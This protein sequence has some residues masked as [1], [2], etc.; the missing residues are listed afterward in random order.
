M[1]VRVTENLRQFKA[2]E[3][4]ADR[5]LHLGKMQFSALLS[6]MLAEFAQH[7]GRRHINAGDGFGRDHHAPYR[8][9][10]CLDGLHQPL[11][12]QFGVGEEQGRVPAEQHQA[13]DQCG[14]RVALQ[15]VVAAQVRYTAQHGE[16]R[17]PAV[18]QEFDDGD[19]H[20][21]ADAGYGPKRG[22]GGK[23]QHG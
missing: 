21:Q 5:V 14:M 15:V 19:D 2:L 17:A 10:R 16:V 13:V 1:K 22:H 20:G 23:A 9:G 3:F 4:V 6:Q 18:P 12:E 8:R 7:V 11:L